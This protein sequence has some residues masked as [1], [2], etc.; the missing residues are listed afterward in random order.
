MT[1]CDTCAGAGCIL[2]S[3]DR[4]KGKAR[5]HLSLITR[6]AHT[7]TGM[8]ECKATGFKAREMTTIRAGGGGCG[9]PGGGLVDDGMRHAKLRDVRVASRGWGVNP[10]TLH[11]TP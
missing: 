2:E 7:G 10:R 11:P 1:E 6:Y 5:R 4:L 3:S 8:A 9:S